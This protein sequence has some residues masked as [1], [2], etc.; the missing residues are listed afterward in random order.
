VN[1]AAAPLKPLRELARHYG[2]QTSYVD[3]A[4]DR[5]VASPESLVAVLR[6]LGAPLDS[7]V[8]APSALVRAQRATRECPID[9]VIVRNPC[10]SLSLHFHPH[11]ND[12]PARVRVRVEFENGDGYSRA[13]RIERAARGLVMHVPGPWPIGYHKLEVSAGRTRNTAHV[14][15]A[16]RKCHPLVQGPAH[17]RWGVF[18]P[19]Y[20]LRTHNDWGAGDFTGLRQLLEWAEGLG[21]DVVGTLPLLAEFLDHSAD[22]S[23]YSPVSRLFWNEFFIDPTATAEWDLSR[24]ARKIA[25]KER[26]AIAQ[27]RAARLVDYPGVTQLKRDVLEALARECYSRPPRRRELEGFLRAHPETANYAKFRA[28]CE[29]HGVPW[30]RWPDRMKNGN[31]RSRDYAE[32]S[33]RYHAY[34]QWIAEQQIRAATLQSPN[35]GRGLYLDLPLGVN[36]AGYDTWREPD[37]FLSGLSAGAPPDPFFTRGQKWG[38]PPFNPHGLRRQGYRHWA[39]CLRHHLR[40]AALLRIDHIM[41]FHRVFCV[42]ESADAAQGVYV[43]YPAKEFYAVLKIESFRAQCAVTGE[44]LGTVPKRVRQ[45][46][47]THGVNRLYVMQFSF[48]GKRVA[49]PPAQSVASLNTHDMVPFAGFYRGDDIAGRV[50]LGLLSKGEAKQEARGRVGMREALT[51]FLRKEGLIGHGLKAASTRTVLRALLRFLAAG[52]AAMVLVNLEDLWLERIQQ[53]TP[54]T[55]SERPNWRRRAAKSL[56]EFSRGR[57]ILKML[58]EIDRLRRT[59]KLT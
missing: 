50:E 46:M 24:P 11:R 49:I 4:G 52:P 54:G 8:D 2:V 37:A 12:A 29:R 41:G 31:L 33:F 30:V 20:A 19:L 17:G 32:G 13:L 3:L 43:Q 39:Q 5:R 23:P 7:P 38:L 58:T 25:E 27:R 26:N 56:D 21:A 44:D 6:S 15:I 40:H 1:A 10:P 22:P 59:R 28:A 14:L 45:S 51:E 18:L 57:A 48:D 47:R 16:P 34:A 53:N 42:P 35:E 55:T 36:P 9:P